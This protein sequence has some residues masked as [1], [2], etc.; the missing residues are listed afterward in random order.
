MSRPFP[1]C[2]LW[3]AHFVAP[4]EIVLPRHNNMWQTERRPLLRRDCLQPVRRALRSPPRSIPLVSQYAKE[5]VGPWVHLVSV[6]LT[7]WVTVATRSVHLSP[8]CP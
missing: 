7:R 8:R 5:A 2:Q 4:G 1:N 3:T 6:C